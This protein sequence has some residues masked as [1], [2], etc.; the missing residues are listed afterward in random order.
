MLIPHTSVLVFDFS[1]WIHAYMLHM[2]HEIIYD[3]MFMKDL[4]QLQT[5]LHIL[6]EFVKPLLA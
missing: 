2:S 4:S 3:Y 5:V 6:S 1:L